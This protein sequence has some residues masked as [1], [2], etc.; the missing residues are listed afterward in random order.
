MTTAL[1]HPQCSPKQSLNQIM[2]NLLTIGASSIAALTSLIST[3]WGQDAVTFTPVDGTTFSNYMSQSAWTLLLDVQH[4]GAGYL[5]T[6]SATN[7]YTT[8]LNA[9][10]SASIVLSESGGL[11]SVTDRILNGRFG[12][13]GAMAGTNISSTTQLTGILI[14]MTDA[15]TPGDGGATISDLYI[16]S[17]YE[18]SVADTTG[19]ATF[20]GALLCSFSEATA[21]LENITFTINQP[22]GSGGE[23]IFVIGLEA[24]SV[25]EPGSLALVL[26]G[27]LALFSTCASHRN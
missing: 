9:S 10:F 26:L 19:G 23:R 11:V 8:S 24:S 15:F 13:T 22:E 1:L 16:G 5:M 17:N 12:S 14:G 4:S 27:G 2:K 3:A 25:P 20:G 7:G 18:P 6:D 21:S